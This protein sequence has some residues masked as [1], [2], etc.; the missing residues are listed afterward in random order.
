MITRTN[1]KPKLQK[2]VLF[3]K[4]PPSSPLKPEVTSTPRRF[5]DK[6]SFDTDIASEDGE[7]KMGDKSF[8]PL[9]TS[10]TMINQS[11]QD[12]KIDKPPEEIDNSYLLKTIIDKI[13]DLR[14]EQRQ[15][16]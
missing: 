15:R 9:G 13:E 10:P 12:E 11:A 6:M 3:S 1:S 7:N 14:N 5:E 2:K 16:F 4:S 8:D